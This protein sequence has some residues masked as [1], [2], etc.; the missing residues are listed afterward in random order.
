MMWQNGGHWG[1]YFPMMMGGGIMMLIF[2]GLVIWLVIYAIRK[3]SPNEKSNH[4]D[5]AVDILRQRYAK[6]E[7]SVEEYRERLKELMDTAK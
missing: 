4:A 6:G 2:W 7:I 5:S 1:N 3:L